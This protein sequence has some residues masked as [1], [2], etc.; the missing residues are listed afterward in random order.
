MANRVTKAQLMADLA[1]ANTDNNKLEGKLAAS[2]RALNELKSTNEGLGRM[3][4]GRGKTI[5]ILDGTLTDKSV[6]IHDLRSV[7]EDRDRAL[8]NARHNLLLASNAAEHWKEMYLGNQKQLDATADVAFLLGL[9]VMRQQNI[10]GAV[11]SLKD[12]ANKAG[13]EMTDEF[14]S[15]TRMTLTRSAAIIEDEMTTKTE[16]PDDQ[17]IPAILR[18]MNRGA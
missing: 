5:R 16:P 4:E 12:A 10:I 9:P 13:V 6:E 3:V 2:E 14:V 15:A 18:L 8:S 7:I 1:V 11:A 17:I